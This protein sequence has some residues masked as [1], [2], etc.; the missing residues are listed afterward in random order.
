MNY[1]L[2]DIKATHSN[3]LIDI[4]IDFNNL[5]QEEINQLFSSEIY[6]KAS[7][8]DCVINAIKRIKQAKLNNE[9]VFI[10]GDYDADGICATT[11][12]KDALDKYGIDCGYYIPDRFN[13]GYGLNAEKVELAYNKG[14]SLIITVDNGVKAYEALQKAKELN[15]DVIITD[16]HLIEQKT[17]FITVHPD[18]MEENFKG[19]CGA[20]VALQLAR[21]LIGNDDFHTALACIATIGDLMIVLNEN[22]NIIKKGLKILNEHKYKVFDL[23]LNKDNV[24]VEDI[25]F[26]I[27]PKLNALGRLSDKFNP[28]NII[29]YYFLENDFN[30]VLQVAQLINGINDTRKKMSSTMSEIANSL[31]KDDD[32]IIIKSEDFHEGIVGLVAGKLASSFNKPAIVLSQHDGILKGSGRSVSGFNLHEFLKDD[33]DELLT[34]GGHSQAVG[35]SLKSDDFN[36]FYQKVLN[37]F[38]KIE[39]IND[40]I[41]AYKV[42][43]VDLSLHNVKEL[44]EL[45]PLGQGVRLPFIAL[46]DLYNSQ[47]RLLKNIYPKYIIDDNLEAICFD[48]NI[49]NKIFKPNIIIG[50]VSVNVFNKKETVSINIKDIE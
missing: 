28:N 37:K 32:F 26:L 42:N 6:L 23:L 8:S 41:V 18:Y 11:L 35:L 15:I 24:T 40:K 43:R 21:N 27:V 48:K 46:T 49:D 22:R 14:Y 44:L 33:F 38:K 19:L 16:H 34:F 25:S 10:G 9:K 29:R 36:S 1:E 12:L 39:I 7:K 47:Y 45:F 31:I 3:K 5:N 20:G 30:K 2:R 50:N 17:D 13:E 4:L